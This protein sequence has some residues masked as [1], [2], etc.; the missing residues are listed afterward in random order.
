MKRFLAVLL[1]FL[2]L[3][4]AFGLIGC[5]S[6]ED[7]DDGKQSVTETADGGSEESAGVSLVGSWESEYELRDNLIG[8]LAELE[9]ISASE[10]AEYFADYKSYT[11]VVTKYAKDGTI[12]VELSDSFYENMEKEI[13]QFTNIVIEAECDKYGVTPEALGTLLSDSLDSLYSSVYN[14]YIEVYTGVFTLLETDGAYYKLSGDKLYIAYEKSEV[15]SA[16]VQTV[17]KLTESELIIES[18]GVE[19]KYTKVK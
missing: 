13:E 8:I 14:T 16:A 15:D 5:D 4:S 18:E 12:S 10:A 1:V 9:Y 6:K 3:F 11:S 7:G 2:M 17:T 19:F